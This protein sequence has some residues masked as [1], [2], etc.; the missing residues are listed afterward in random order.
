MYNTYFR[1]AITMLKQ[2]KFVSII[3]IA[4]TALAIMMIMVVIVSRSINSISIAPE[5]N[6]DRMLYSKILLRSN[7]KGETMMSRGLDYES[8]K[9]YLSVLKTPEKISVI[10]NYYNNKGLTKS[11]YTK[12]R[13]AADLKQTDAVYWELISLS[14]IEGKPFTEADFSS[15]IKN[16]V[17]TEGLARKLF[18][19]NT[20]VGNTF[21]LDFVPYKVVGVVKNVSK[22]FQF[23]YADIWI[24]YTT[25]EGYEES[26][27][28]T[29]ML[30]KDKKDFDA[31]R[32]EVRAC[33]RRYNATVPNGEHTITFMGP[34]DQEI[35]KLNTS[36]VFPDEKGYYRRFVFI[37]IVLLLVP[38]I[39]LSGFSLSRI[40]KRTE[41]IGIRKAFGAKKYT[42]LMQVLYENMVT[43]LIG[44]IIGLILSYFTVSWLKEWL[45]GVGADATIPLSTVVSIPVFLAAFCACM[46]LNLLSSG[47]PAYR[48]SKMTIVD[49]L[50]KKEAQ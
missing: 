21:D 40:K 7:P 6:R 35:Q 38:A 32:E 18:G 49:S 1:Q 45:L 48:A 16:A 28:M 41:E 47:I 5:N 44:G 13:I 42:I 25:K 31:I 39:N 3:S 10:S 36:N 46:L 14:F 9:N 29:M 34:Y 27:F 12:N 8:V 43:S 17:I 2:N 24:P 4:G 11:S 33:E 50:T 37:I 19:N 15:G 23:A 30:A 26:A 20:A 22:V